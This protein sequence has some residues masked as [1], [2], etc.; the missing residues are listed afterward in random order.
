MEGEIG[1]AAAPA[2][3]EQG[4]TERTPGAAD[5]LGSAPPG[6][7]LAP[8]ACACD[9]S[10]TCGCGAT[11]P[12]RY[13]YAVGVLRPV[14]PSR[15]LH[16]EMLQA[17]DRS[18]APGPGNQLDFQVMRLGENVHVARDVCFVLQVG[19]MDTYLVKPRSYLELYEMVN[20]LQQQETSNE[21][22]YAVI[23]GLM[24]SLAP[25]EACG[26]R[27]L[28][29]VV[30]NQYMSFTQT[31]MVAA[32]QGSKPAGEI[33]GAVAQDM[34]R[35]MVLDAPDDAGEMPEHRALNYLALQ[36]PDIYAQATSY[37]QPTSLNN[38]WQQVMYFAGA[39]AQPAEV[40]GTRVVM[41][42]VLTY[43]ERHTQDRLESTCKVDVTG[44][45]PFLVTPLAT[46]IPE[47]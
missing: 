18:E 21:P 45:F 19:G 2:A 11:P 43:R 12:T 33:D 41:D 38:P 44:Q 20:D 1:S 40:Q 15:S 10:A 31:A 36:Y 35:R 9:G 7:G 17:A 30:C 23:V 16:E 26:G 8:Q 28:P 42:I 34:L 39:R 24:G 32:L 27:Q 3:P 29:V 37:L 5:P 22:L 4:T 14:Y 47:T 46:R 13:V 25:P 6:A